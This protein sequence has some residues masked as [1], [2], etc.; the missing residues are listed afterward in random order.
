MAKTGRIQYLHDETT[1]AE[2]ILCEHSSI[3]YPTHSHVSV[4]TAGMVLEGGIILTDGDGPRLCQEGAVFGILPYT[5]HSI[6]ADG[7]Y[8]L[9]S[10]CIQSQGLPPSG[11][12]LAPPLPDM[13]EARMG[14]ALP[15]PLLEC[16]EG[17]CAV[18]Q[19]EIDDPS[20]E[21]LKRQLE[22]HPESRVSIDE[23]ALQAGG[24]PDAPPVPDA[25]PRPEGAAASGPVRHHDR[26]GP[27][28]WFLRSKPLHQ[29]V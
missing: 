14:T 27:D 11:T 22:Q 8:T 2:L 29:A 28:R 20:I 9:L 1:H 23:M 17:L 13:L 16:L 15:A 7:P 6:R 3:S 18:P 12:G 21:R 4:L 5:P 24:R 25:E 19:P 10:L 26:S